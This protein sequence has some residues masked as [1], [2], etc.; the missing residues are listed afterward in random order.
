M[1]T[2]STGYISWVLR[3][4]ILLKVCTLCI[5]RRRCRVFKSRAP[6]LLSQWD[7]RFLLQNLFNIPEQ[8]SLWSFLPKQT[9]HFKFIA[10]VVGLEAGRKVTDFI[11]PF[12][13]SIPALSGR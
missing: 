4:M 13:T 2:L 10:E 1:P 9:A 5:P 8:I 12:A 6:L 3:K 11:L 7:G